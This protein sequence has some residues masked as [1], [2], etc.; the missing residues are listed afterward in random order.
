MSDPAKRKDYNEN[1][2]FEVDDF[3]VEVGRTQS[4]CNNNVLLVLILFHFL[5]KRERHIC[6]ATFSLTGVSEA[7]QANDIEP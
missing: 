1:A 6:S 4:R 7:V 5:K 3:D 2:E